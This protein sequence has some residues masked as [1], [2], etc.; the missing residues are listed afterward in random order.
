MILFIKIA[1]ILSTKVLIRTEVAWYLMLFRS[2][3]NFFLAYFI[4]LIFT[5]DNYIWRK[6]NVS[7]A[8][9][10]IL[11]SFVKHNIVYHIVKMFI[12]L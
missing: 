9:V 7:P 2:N 1:N 8:T 4:H 6:I 11:Y 3:I 12:I 10:A 5:V